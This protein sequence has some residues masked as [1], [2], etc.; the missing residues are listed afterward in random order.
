MLLIGC[1][2]DVYLVCVLCLPDVWIL[3]CVSVAHPMFAC[4]VP[5]ACIMV[6]S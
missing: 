2:Y 1:V 6:F 5:G 3:C 4:R